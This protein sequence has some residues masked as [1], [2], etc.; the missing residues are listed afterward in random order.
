TSF[1]TRRSSDL[2]V[3]FIRAATSSGTPVTTAGNQTSTTGASITDSGLLL[4]LRGL[5]RIID[6]DPERR[7][8][9]VE[10]G[11]LLG[12]LNRAAAAHGLFFAPDPTSEEESTVGGA[13]AC[14]ASG[15]RTMRYGP[16][17]DH[18]RALKV[19]TADVAIH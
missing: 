1:P 18:V 4:S 12:D 15:A 19:M 3:D 10:A 6:I 17:R 14:N 5:D 2:T 9:R 16:T 7:V 13:I 11:V 8:A